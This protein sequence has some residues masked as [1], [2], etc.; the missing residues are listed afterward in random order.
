M[1]ATLQTSGQRQQAKT[2]RSFF[3]EEAFLLLMLVL[4]LVVMCMDRRQRLFRCSAE[5]GGSL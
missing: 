3:D 4:V 1:R 2:R 5:G